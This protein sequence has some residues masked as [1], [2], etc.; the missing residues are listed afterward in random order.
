M[1][2]DSSGKPV[3]ASVFAAFGVQIPNGPEQNMSDRV[4]V[5]MNDQR[6]GMINDLHN[7]VSISYS[8]TMVNKYKLT[9]YHTKLDFGKK[10][11]A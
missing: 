11:F 9:K 5:E 4:F 7:Y 1:A 2:W 10:I 8:T 3:N 6:N